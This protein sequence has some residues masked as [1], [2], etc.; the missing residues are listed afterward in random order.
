MSV[1]TSHCQKTKTEPHVVTVS[2]L[3][4]VVECLR[5]EGDTMNEQQNLREELFPE[6]M[7]EP[8]DFIRALA[9]YILAQR[10]PTTENPTS[11]NQ[12]TGRSET[13]AK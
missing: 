10:N 8:E 4:V 9:E 6:G 7:P 12:T 13:E 3:Q 5:K 11:E 2:D 1:D